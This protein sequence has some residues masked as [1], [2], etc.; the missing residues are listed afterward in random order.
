[1]GAECE[2]N[3]VTVG[4]CSGSLSCADVAARTGQVLDIELLP[5][6]FGQFLQDKAGDDIGR[7]TG[8]EWND[9]AHRTGG[10]S[11]SAYKR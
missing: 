1:M 8:R 10:I 3:G 11:L 4:C 2:E 9:H 6:L 5:Q 7:P